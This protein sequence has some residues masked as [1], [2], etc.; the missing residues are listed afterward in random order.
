MTLR[1]KLRE[2]RDSLLIATITNVA[3][4]QEEEGIVA[5]I[6]SWVVVQVVAKRN[7]SLLRLVV[8]IE[9]LRRSIRQ[10]VTRHLAYVTLQTHSLG[11]GKIAI[12]ITLCHVDIADT[13]QCALRLW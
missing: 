5:I 1:R 6:S 4:T 2:R 13:L 11:I 9:F 10:R 12:G 8:K 3:V 7:S